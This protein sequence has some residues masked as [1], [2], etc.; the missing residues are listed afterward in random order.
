MRINSPKVDLAGQYLARYHNYYEAKLGYKSFCCHLSQT[1]Y[2]LRSNREQLHHI[3]LWSEFEE[4]IR[5]G[6]A[7]A[8][9]TL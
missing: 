7:H 1:F 4:R 6:N 8:Q 9:V 5:M 2:M 3:L